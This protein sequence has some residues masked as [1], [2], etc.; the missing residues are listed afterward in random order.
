MMWLSHSWACNAFKERNE[1]T[2]KKYFIKKG[3]T[4]KDWATR[5][6]IL[7][8]NIICADNRLTMPYHLW[9]NQSLV[10]QHQFG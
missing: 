8:S 5:C 1:R 10:Y 6:I 4:K 3:L 9:Y 2:V 7:Y